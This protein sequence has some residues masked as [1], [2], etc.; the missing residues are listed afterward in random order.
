MKRGF[1]KKYIL[2]ITPLI[3]AIW[4]LAIY[5]FKG[6]YPFGTGTIIDCDLYQAVFRFTI[7]FVMLGTAVA[8]FMTLRPPA[9]PEEM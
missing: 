7:M 3:T 6:I 2:I 1:D 8:C 4:L 5:Y 9:V